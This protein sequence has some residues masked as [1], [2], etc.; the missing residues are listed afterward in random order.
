MNLIKR[1]WV[2]VLKRLKK[3]DVN[4]WFK[5][6][7]TS[8]FPMV[9]GV[10]SHVIRRA[11]DL[12]TVEA[13]AKD[14]RIRDDQEFVDHIMLIWY[15]CWCFNNLQGAE[16]YRYGAVPL[17]EEMLRLCEQHDLPEPS[18]VLISEV[19]QD[20]AQVPPPPKALRGLVAVKGVRR[21]ASP[22]PEKTRKRG[23]EK[24]S[25]QSAKRAR[26][27]PP[28]R[29][30]ASP[31]PPPPQAKKKES[32]RGKAQSATPPPPPPKPER[33]ERPTKQPKQKQR[34]KEPDPLPTLSDAAVS[35]L[36]GDK[37]F[38]NPQSFEDCV[39]L[40]NALNVLCEMDLAKVDDVSEEDAKRRLAYDIQSHEDML[41]ALRGT[42]SRIIEEGEGAG[43]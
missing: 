14:G 31:A 16:V 2:D 11:M 33:V 17:A 37:A 15:N 1:K 39:A 22:V 29:K 35:I 23:G 19:R 6:P 21:V 43:V 28:P 12:G 8:K 38:Y 5:E 10:Y 30:S 7:V 34:Q 4:D 26:A 9:A 41:V 18:E 42:M 32:R 27:T 3:K 25:T 40:F 24:A 13:M 20:G 36:E